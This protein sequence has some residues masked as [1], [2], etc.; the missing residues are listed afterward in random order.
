MI[1]TAL[2]D[3]NSRIA[4]LMATKLGVGGDPTLKSRL[5]KGGK[6]LPHKLR[7]QA[8]FLAQQEELWANPRMRRTIDSGKVQRAQRDLLSYLDGLDRKDQFFGRMIGILAPLMFNVLLIFVAFVVWLV[9]T[10]RV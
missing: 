7:Q 10:G 3:T 8:R 2:P 1:D 5:T 9:M 4:A 6:R